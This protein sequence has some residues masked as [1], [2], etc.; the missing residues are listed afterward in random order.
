MITVEE[1]NKKIKGLDSFYLN[2]L[3]IKFCIYNPNPIQNKNDKEDRSDCSIRAISKYLNKSWEE[4]FR[5]MSEYCIKTGTVIGSILSII[6]YIKT[7]DLESIDEGDYYSVAD[8]MYHNKK[9]K[10]LI[11][12]NNH[13]VCYQNG[14][15]YDN[16][17]AANYINYFL[18]EEIK[19]IFTIK[20]GKKI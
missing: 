11:M 14:K 18:V 8:F 4:T 3:G 13:V 5:E 9:G 20:K 16:L 17:A 10:Y 12:T 2:L 7:Y 1:H 6:E 19:D 15:I